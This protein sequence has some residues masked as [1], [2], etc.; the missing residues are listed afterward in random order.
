MVLRE[1]LRLAVSI[2]KRRTDG[3]KS[4]TKKRTVL[5]RKLTRNINMDLMAERSEKAANYE[6]NATDQSSVKVSE[7]TYNTAEKLDDQSSVSPRK[8]QYM[9]SD[10]RA[11]LRNRLRPSGLDLRVDESRSPPQE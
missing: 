7:N 11:K 10:E 3:E 4:I 8:P 2:K 5:G 9:S 6:R 1:R